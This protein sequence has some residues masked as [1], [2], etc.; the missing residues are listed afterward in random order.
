MGPRDP[1]LT[2]GIGRKNRR[3][4]RLALSNRENSRMSRRSPRSVVYEDYVA[5]W[6]DSS[7]PGFL[8]VLPS[9]FHSL[10]YALITSLDSNPD[11]ASLFE[12]DPGFNTLMAGARPLGRGL[13]LPTRMLL[14][15]E[16]RD[17][18]FFGFDE[19]WFFPD[20]K[21]EPKPETAW[22]VGPARVDQ[23]TMNQLGSWMTANSCSLALGDGEGLN[24]VMKAR[25]LARYV[26]GHSLSQSVP[27]SR[28]D[29]VFEEDAGE[30]PVSQN[31]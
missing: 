14:G 24:L 2:T 5:G 20:E 27:T 28:G 13:L 19:V 3:A 29:L 30:K 22:L 23:K 21:T 17:Q 31:R 25:G 11:L 18:V 26:L 6:L 7:I 9:A 1:M 16:S 8:E 4:S 15:I 12:Q 10:E